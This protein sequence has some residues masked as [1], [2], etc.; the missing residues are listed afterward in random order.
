MSDQN[1]KWRPTQ[2]I[3]RN[4][5]I[6]ALGMVFMLKEGRYIPEGPAAHGWHALEHK[7]FT[8]TAAHGVSEICKAL[9]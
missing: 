5:G 3:W 7:R 2:T 1:S 6:C 4:T 9:D 8:D